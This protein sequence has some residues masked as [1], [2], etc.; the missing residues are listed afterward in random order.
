MSFVLGSIVNQRFFIYSI[1]PQLKMF[2]IMTCIDSVFSTFMNKG[3]TTECTK[4]MGTL[5]CETQCKTTVQLQ[6][7]LNVT[8]MTREA[9]NSI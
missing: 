6:L 3:F 5:G 4:D 7:T 1:W 9:K 8:S 2:S